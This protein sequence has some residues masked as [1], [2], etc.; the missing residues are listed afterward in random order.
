MEAR[1]CH[2]FIVFTQHA[3]S[4]GINPSYQKKKSNLSQHTQGCLISS[5]LPHQ[6]GDISRQTWFLQVELHKYWKQGNVVDEMWGLLQH[7]LQYFM[8]FHW[9]MDF[10]LPP[11]MRTKCNKQQ[12]TTFVKQLHSTFAALYICAALKRPFVRFLFGALRVFFFSFR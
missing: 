11:S 6:K 2:L 3:Q 4:L 1:G 8:K 7:S 12:N 10:M 5:S 9:E